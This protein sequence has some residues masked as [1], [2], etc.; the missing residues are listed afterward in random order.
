M[1]NKSRSRGSLLFSAIC[2][3]IT[4]A[5]W[6][7]TVGFKTSHQDVGLLI[8]QIAVLL[9]SLLNAIINWYCYANYDKNNKQTI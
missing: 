6:T 1:K 3:T 5:L 9:L 2:W 7:V 8:L 4:T